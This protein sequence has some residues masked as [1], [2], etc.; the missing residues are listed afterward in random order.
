M[1]HTNGVSLSIGGYSGSLVSE[2]R[3]NTDQIGYDLSNRST[4]R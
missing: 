4:K 2:Y 1:K 3:G